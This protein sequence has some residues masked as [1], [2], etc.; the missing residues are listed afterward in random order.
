MVEFK[1]LDYQ[2]RNDIDWAEIGPILNTVR[3]IDEKQA[4]WRVDASY[5]YADPEQ[6]VKI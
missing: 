3:T 5:L 1:D 4:N 2:R 6:T